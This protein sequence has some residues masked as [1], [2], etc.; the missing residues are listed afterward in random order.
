MKVTEKKEKIEI[1]TMPINTFVKNKDFYTIEDLVTIYSL[2]EKGQKHYKNLKQDMKA[3][4]LKLENLNSKVRNANQYI[5]EIDKHKKSI[6]EFWKFANKDEKLALEM[7]E[8]K[9]ND[10]NKDELKKSFD[11]EMDFEKLGE[12]VDSLQR[13]KLSHEETD[14]LFIAQ[15]ELLNSINMVRSKNIVKYDLE[16]FGSK[17]LLLVITDQ[18]SSVTTFKVTKVLGHPDDSVVINIDKVGIAESMQTSHIIIEVDKQFGADDLIDARIYSPSFLQQIESAATYA[19]D[20][21]KVVLCMNDQ[22]Y[23]LSGDIRYIYSLFGSDLHLWGTV[24]E[25]DAAGLKTFSYGIKTFVYVRIEQDQAKLSKA[26]D[27]S[28]S[29]VLTLHRQTD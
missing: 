19:D 12:E 4:E 15:T 2:H 21:G 18:P 17:Q 13:K 10:N 1:D 16:W 25:G 9:E 24:R 27:F 6:F 26:A 5:E 8:D 29:D 23:E 7:G 14:S 3:L 11:F 28:G 20:S 22:A